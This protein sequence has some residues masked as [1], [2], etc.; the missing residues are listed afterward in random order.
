MGTDHPISAEDNFPPTL[1]GRVV[2]QTLIRPA[3][4][5]FSVLE[6]I[7]NPG[8]QS[9]QIA[10]CLTK[11]SLKIGHQQTGCSSRECD[12]IGGYEVVANA[13]PLAKDDFTTHL[14]QSA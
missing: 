3:Q 11:V 12:W 4:L 13:T 10:E 5:V 14:T 9:I 8:A 1:N 2:S 7:F 6:A